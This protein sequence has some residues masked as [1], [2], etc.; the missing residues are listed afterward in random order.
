MDELIVQKNDDNTEIIVLEEGKIVEYYLY[1]S[2]NIPKIGNVY[3]GI[4]KDVK[5]KIKTI[6]VDI[7]LLRAGYLELK[8]FDKTYKKGDKLLVQV[9]KEE[10]NNKGTKLS[11]KIT[12]ISERIASKSLLKKEAEL[13]YDANKIASILVNKFVKKSTKKIFINDKELLKDLENLDNI[14]ELVYKKVNFIDEFGLLTEFTKINARKIWLKSGGYI[15]I[16][17]TE[18]LTAID[19]NSGKYIGK[20]YDSKEDIFLNINKEAGIE[21]IKQIRLKNIGGIILIDFI[22]MEKPEN[23]EEIIKLLKKEAKKDRSTINIYD[24]TRLGLVEISRKKL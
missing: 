4:I 1:D 17:K 3:V 7:G 15:V 22:N 21:A 19:V 9:I 24:F 20:K 10:Q 14:P 5:P 13:I 11:N 23:R 18:A 16:D 6:F 8:T 12:S 2:Q